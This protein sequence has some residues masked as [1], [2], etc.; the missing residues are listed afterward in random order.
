MGY[1]SALDYERILAIVASASRGTP[2]EPLPVHVLEMIR[3]LVGCDVASYCDGVPWERGNRRIWIT[4]ITDPWTDDE[5]A[6]VDR[7]RFDVPLYPAAAT[8]D[9][10]VRATDIMPLSRYRR[11]DL[12]QLVGRGHGIEY[13]MDYWMRGNAGH[14]RGL[15][16][17]DS[18]RDFSDR[19][20]DA[21][22]VLG[23][24]LRTALGRWD[25]VP[26][27]RASAALTSREAE[28][29]SLVARGRTNRQIG[30]ALSISPHTVRK[31]L[32]NAFSSIGVHSR[33]EAVLETY[34]R[35]ASTSRDLE[36]LRPT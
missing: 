10:A 7:F 33:A 15:R 8:V 18:A 4:P 34:G 3:A 22:E 35:P 31:H 29:L 25:L 13:G 2:S 17:D 1:V 11:L 23:R 19:S 16:F 28:I 5:K 20:R 12:Y 30:L 6:I 27:S 14:V 32:E 26:G 9:R 36:L 21:V 24:H